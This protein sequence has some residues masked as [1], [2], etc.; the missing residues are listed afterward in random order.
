MD[1]RGKVGPLWRGLDA[2]ID[3]LAAPVVDSLNQICQGRA[4]AGGRAAAA[5][6]IGEIDADVGVVLVDVVD[7]RRDVFEHAI[8]PRF[9]DLEDSREV[10]SR[11]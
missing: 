9:D 6:R 8:L 10:D 2:E 11:H 5:A 7:E 1:Q 3:R 4:A